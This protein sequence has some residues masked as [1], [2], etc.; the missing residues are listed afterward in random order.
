MDPKVEQS[1]VFGWPFLQYLLH[2]FCPCI[3][4]RQEQFWGKMFDMGEWLFPL[5]E[6]VL[7]YYRWSLQVLSPLF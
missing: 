3:P 6:A 2:F 4:F 5:L 7:I 1:L